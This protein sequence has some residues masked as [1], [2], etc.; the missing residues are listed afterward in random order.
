MT[1]KNPPPAQSVMLRSKGTVQKNYPVKLLVSNIKN[2]KLSGG[3]EIS[4]DENRWVRLDR[5]PQ[6]VGYF[7]GS[8]DSPSPDKKQL[9]RFTEKVEGF[10]LDLSQRAKGKRD[11]MNLLYEGSGVKKVIDVVADRTTESID[12]LSGAKIL[13]EVRIR[14]DQQDKYNDL[15]ATKLAEALEEISAL[16]KIIKGMANK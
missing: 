7:Q 14:L 4:L 5:H 2:G 1:E 10:F 3:E 15:L 6:L 12:I 9:G 13:E 11:Q 8:A 16:K